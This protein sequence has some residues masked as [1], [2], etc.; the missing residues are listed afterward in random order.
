MSI[1]VV[2]IRD[3]L[4]INRAE[5]LLLA[6]VKPDILVLLP[7]DP[8]IHDGT[9]QTTLTVGH[10][11]LYGVPTIATKPIAIRQ[12]AV[13]AI[14]PETGMELLLTTRM[15]GTVDVILPSRVTFGPKV[16]SLRR[17]ASIR[18]LPQ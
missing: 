5:K 4:Q 12:G 18:V 2:D 10:A 16:S 6:K 15:K 11:S 14:G 9:F 1:T 17:P 7:D 3:S 8:Q 13:F